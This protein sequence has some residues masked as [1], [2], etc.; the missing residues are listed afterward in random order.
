MTC[1][2]NSQAHK[3]SSLIACATFCREVKIALSCQY[4]WNVN[5]LML[6]EAAHHG[7][8]ER[9]A[10]LAQSVLMGAHRR[11]DTSEATHLL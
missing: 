2:R 11:F 10:T 9:T 4:P 6:K 8:S 1:S 5:M 3:V 7:H